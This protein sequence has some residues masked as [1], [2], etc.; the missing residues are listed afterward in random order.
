MT[1]YRYFVWVL[2]RSIESHSGYE[3]TAFALR[4]EGHLERSP[5]FDYHIPRG[6]LVELLSKALL[7]IEVET[8]CKGEGLISDCCAPF[9]LLKR[10]A[11]AADP[12]EEL[13]GTADKNGKRTTGAGLTEAQLKRKADTPAD[14]DSED[15]RL[16]RSVEPEGE[17]SSA[18][19]LDSELIVNALLLT[20]SFAF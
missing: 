15:R 19:A 20:F 9:R 5:Y 1:I 6:E 13:N 16:K 7:Y 2:S 14:G 4:A 17:S 3:H 12:L 18:M 11:C 10:H 8:H